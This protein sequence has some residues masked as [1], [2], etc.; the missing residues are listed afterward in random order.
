M[1]EFNEA[2][3][4]TLEEMQDVIIDNLVSSESLALMN[5]EYDLIDEMILSKRDN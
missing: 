2:E 1:T 5:D 3:V 4:M